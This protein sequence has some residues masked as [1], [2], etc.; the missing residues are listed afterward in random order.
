MST[1]QDRLAICDHGEIQVLARGRVFCGKCHRYG[2][3]EA[4]ARAAQPA[5]LTV[6]ALAEALYVADDD[7]NGKRTP[8]ERARAILAALIA[9]TE[10]TR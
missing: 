6:E 1:P 7:Y 10:G 2:G 9:A 3:I 5:T 4:E 8:M